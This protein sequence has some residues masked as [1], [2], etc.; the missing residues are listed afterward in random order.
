MDRYINV[1][2]LVNKLTNNAALKT[3]YTLLLMTNGEIAKDEVDK[4]F[5]QKFDELNPTERGL[6]RKALQEAEKNLLI[7]TQN[8]HQEIKDYKNE[9]QHLK[10]AA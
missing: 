3:Y 2:N 8:L 10:Q 7:A 1:N 9:G 6:M 4:Q 5:W